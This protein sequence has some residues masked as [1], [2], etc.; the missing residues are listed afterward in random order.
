MM[1]G[2]QRLDSGCARTTIQVHM[3]TGKTLHQ[4]FVPTN[5]DNSDGLKVISHT[6]I[7]RYYY[8]FH[9]LQGDTKR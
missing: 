6:P 7:L 2:T 4:Q 5:F 9:V 8:A 3:D 1:T